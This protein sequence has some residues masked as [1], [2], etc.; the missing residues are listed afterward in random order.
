MGGTDVDDSTI[1]KIY[2]I[3]FFGNI[4]LVYV[5]PLFINAIYNFITKVKLSNKKAKGF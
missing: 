3:N 5:A 2:K 1:F 4:D